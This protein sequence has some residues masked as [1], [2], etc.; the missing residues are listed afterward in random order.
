MCSA[1]LEVDSRKLCKGLIDGNS[2]R[3][4]KS[5]DG[6][7]CDVNAPCFPYSFETW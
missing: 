2:F 3:L 4:P 1:K 5:V 6:L 7:A